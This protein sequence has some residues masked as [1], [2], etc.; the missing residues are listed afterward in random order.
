MT[1]NI[2]IIASIGILCTDTYILDDILEADNTYL[3][4]TACFCY[5][6]LHLS[7]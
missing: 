6:N 2:A 4:Q 7:T 1:F 3:F 5:Y